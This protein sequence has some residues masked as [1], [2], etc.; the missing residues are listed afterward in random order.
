MPSRE[1]SGS[2]VLAACH[3][4]HPST[5][6]GRLER[7]LQNHLKYGRKLKRFEF[8][9]KRIEL[10]IQAA[11]QKALAVANG[12]EDWSVSNDSDSDDSEASPD[13]PLPSSHFF[14]DRDLRT[15][16]LNYHIEPPSRDYKLQPPPAPGS[17]SP[18]VARIYEEPK[19]KPKPK[20]KRKRKR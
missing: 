18:P 9:R 15:A 5:K 6:L 16:Q 19:P 7:Y 17:Y 13:R 3:N 14:A 20:P 1:V 2:V 10:E 8:E 12:T 4:P 11:R